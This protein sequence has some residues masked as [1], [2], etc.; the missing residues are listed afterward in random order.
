MRLGAAHRS[1][2]RQ[3]TSFNN[4]RDA[5]RSGLDHTTYRK[6][7]AI[8]T[9]KEHI[10]VGRGSMRARQPSGGRPGEEAYPA[11]VLGWRRW[12]VFG[13]VLNIGKV[14]LGRWGG[15]EIFNNTPCKQVRSSARGPVFSNDSNPQGHTLVWALRFARV[16]Y[17]FQ[18]RLSKRRKCGWT[19]E[20]NRYLA[21]SLV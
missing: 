2:H 21:G 7:V 5:H 17:H 15:G 4:T 20:C 1:T 8:K 9:G 14:H 13:E 12:L 3:R 18:S 16:E 11:H 19:G 6:R 10:V